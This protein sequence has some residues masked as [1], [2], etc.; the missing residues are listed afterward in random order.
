MTVVLPRVPTIVAFTMRGD[1]PRRVTLIERKDPLTI[2]PSRRFTVEADQRY[3]P[4]RCFGETSSYGSSTLRSHGS[5][6]EPMKEFSMSSV[7]P[8]DVEKK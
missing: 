4:Q 2:D 8:P 3:G 5:A 1:S 6:G 7:R